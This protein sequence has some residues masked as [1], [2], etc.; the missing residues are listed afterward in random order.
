MWVSVSITQIKL[1]QLD[2]S[3]TGAIVVTHS[4]THS[5]EMSYT[6]PSKNIV[7]CCNFIRYRTNVSSVENLNVLCCFERQDKRGEIKRTSEQ[8][9]VNHLIENLITNLS[10]N[11]NSVS[12]LYWYN[13]IV[14]LSVVIIV[15]HVSKGI[16]N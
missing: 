16:H 4:L 9:R 13:N 2:K 10:E 11:K 7:N 14:F 5:L 15:I 1:V 12:W 6:L 3:R 8:Q